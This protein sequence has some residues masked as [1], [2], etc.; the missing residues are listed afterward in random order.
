MQASSRRIIIGAVFFVIT[1]IVA[2]TGYMLAG[3]TPLDA[4]YM[5]IITI[6]GVGYG[7]VKPLES[8]ALKIFTILVIIAGTSSAV[9]IVGG[10]VQLV[11]EGEINR[12]LTRKR[13]T[14]EID[15]L[16]QHAVICGFGRIG[17][18]LARRLQESQQ[19]F[20]VIDNDP[21]RM[22]EAEEMGY[23]TC[24]GNATD[25][26]ILKTAGI[27]RAKTLATV[28]SDDALN[29]FITLTGRELNPG[30][31]ILA[32][33]EL[34]S[35]E[36]KLRLAGANHVVLPASIGALR[37]AQLITQPTT[38]DFLAQSDRRSDL[39]E[40]LAD[41]DIQMD[42]FAI[43][44]DSPLIGGTIGDIEMR[45]KGTFIIVALRQNSGA[46]M[47]HPDREVHLAAGDTVLI[48][49]HC[50]DLPKFLRRHTIQ[51]NLRYRGARMKR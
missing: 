38:M 21:D 49:G 11:T 27:E 36:K 50:G 14:R 20:V 43:P 19:P 18:M 44:Y 40:L 29:V 10:F 17:Q 16:N 13:M 47:I 51:Q 28:L 48:M 12:A 4:L 37:M 6:F 46:V 41:I 7:E 35:T 3:W 5:V 45:G 32:R 2:M 23:L 33:G 25:E 24:R 1:L 26:A 15:N 8:P 30:L 34:P 42:E 22:T 31:V 39:N 9:Y